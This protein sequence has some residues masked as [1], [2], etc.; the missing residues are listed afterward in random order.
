VPALEQRYA[1]GSC[2]FVKRSNGQETLACVNAYDAEEAFYTVEIE[3]LG[4]EMTEKCHYKDLR[5]ASVLEGLIG[6]C[7]RFPLR[8]HGR[9]Q[10]LASCIV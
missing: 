6:S 3:M 9:R 10:R 8:F 1:I 4:S 5:A 2:V 7:A